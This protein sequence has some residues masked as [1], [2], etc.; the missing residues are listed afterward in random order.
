MIR[1]Y[2]TEENAA[3]LLMRDVQR[4]KWCDIAAALDRP[5]YACVRAHHEKLQIQA[6][7][8]EERAAAPNTR[9][10]RGCLTCGTRF[11]SSHAGNRWCGCAREEADGFAEHD[12]IGIC[13]VPE[14]PIAGAAR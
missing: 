3:I 13:T 14:A 10:M 9:A 11:L 12:V 6:A 4:M 5:S 2:S 8:R 7:Q 1:R